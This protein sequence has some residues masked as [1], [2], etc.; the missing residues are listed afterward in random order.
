[1]KEMC[2]YQCVCDAAMLPM[3]VQKGGTGK[4]TQKRT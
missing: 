4:E 1:M 2:H 3:K